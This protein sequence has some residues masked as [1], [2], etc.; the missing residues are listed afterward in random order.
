MG[1]RS[2]RKMKDYVVEAEDGRRRIDFTRW[3][4]EMTKTEWRRTNPALKVTIRPATTADL[5]ATN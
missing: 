4:A 2:L 5:Q 3:D 1:S